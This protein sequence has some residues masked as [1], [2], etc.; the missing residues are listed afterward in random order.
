MMHTTF[1]GFW[2][3]EEG[4]GFVVVAVVGSRIC[5]HT[6]WKYEDTIKEDNTSSTLFYPSSKILVFLS[7]YATNRIAC[8][9]ISNIP[10]PLSLSKTP[11]TNAHK[12]HKAT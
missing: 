6:Y 5:P 8:Q 1:K 3:V 12:F 2:K 7:F 10:S 9:P 11:K 4:E